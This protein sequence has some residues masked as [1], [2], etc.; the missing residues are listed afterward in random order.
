MS[1]GDATSIAFEDGRMDTSS[2]AASPVGELTTHFAEHITLKHKDPKS[3]P[4]PTQDLKRQRQ[5]PSSPIL[6]SRPPSIRGPNIRRYTSG[7]PSR[8][9]PSRT[10]RLSPESNTTILPPTPSFQRLKNYVATPS[11]EESQLAFL[12][13]NSPEK[14]KA[15]AGLRQTKSE[16]L[17]MLLPGFYKR[18]S[19]YHDTVGRSWDGVGRVHRLSVVHEWLYADAVRRQKDE[20]DLDVDVPENSPESG[21]L[22]D[23]RDNMGVI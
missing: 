13:E 2:R 19:H 18:N 23:H 15:K 7:S 1:G 12:P 22:R 10:S 11:Y 4:Q 9:G 5:D 14:G 16:P 3:D 17:Y 8:S 6:L 21:D 20:N